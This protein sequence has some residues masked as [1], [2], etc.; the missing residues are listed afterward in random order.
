M[1]RAFKDQ[2]VEYTTNVDVTR[3]RDGKR[4]T[5]NPAGRAVSADIWEF[6]NIGCSIRFLNPHLF[7]PEIY[8]LNAT[9]QEYFSC[10]VGS[11]VYLTPPNSQGFA[12]HYDDIE[13]LVLQVE[14]K[15]RWR[16]YAPRSSEE[17][18]PRV[19][20]KNFDECE[21]GSPVLDIILEPGDLLYFP[22]GYI[23]QAN[24]VEGFHSLHVTL[25]TYQKNSWADLMEILLPGALA[26]AVNE[27]VE[28]RRGIPLNTSQL[29]GAAHS[30][31]VESTERAQLLNG[32]RSMC[33]KVLE[34]L[35]IDDAV[36]QLQKKFQHDALPPILSGSERSRSAQGPHCKTKKG[37]VQSDAG[38]FTTTTQF[39][40]L[41]ANILRMVHEEGEVRLY[42]H[43]DNSRFY[44]EYEP[45]F[46]ELESDMVPAVEELIRA[47][48]EY[49]SAKKGE[50]DAEAYLNVF[51]ALWSRGLVVVRRMPTN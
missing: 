6:Y 51:I 20:S 13:A 10:M 19:S 26:L 7:F 15:K 16:V 34:K 47:Y 38:D 21:I 37:L 4:E 46:L 27:N 45:V 5:L 22:R 39:R 33:K 30:N 36:D 43:S 48:P 28:F 23:H 44:H 49:V 50:D 12:P 31:V 17:V 9:L 25:S 3:Y 40:L 42:Y 14:G 11:N 29:L 2:R 1:D 32:I 41:R 8:K 35:P 24:T 18:L